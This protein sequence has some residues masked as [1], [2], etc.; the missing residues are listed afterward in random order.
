MNGPSALP[1]YTDATM[2]PSARPLLLGRVDRGHDRRRG[3]EHHRVSAA[4]QGAQGDEHRLREGERAEEGY[5]RVSHHAR[6]KH[7]PPAA[8]VGYSSEGHEEHRRGQKIG[9][10]D[11]AQA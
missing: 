8:D 11:P 10:R 5:H 3:A 7:L 1:E 9:G 6:E 4:L 2:T